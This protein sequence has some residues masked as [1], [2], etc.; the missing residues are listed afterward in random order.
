[1]DNK[2]AIAFLNS[3]TSIREATEAF[4]NTF[5][6]PEGESHSIRRKFGQLKL[7]REPF[8]KKNDLN[9]WEVIH[10]YSLQAI[11][12][13]KK[14]ISEEKIIFETELSQDTRKPI[15]QLTNKGLKKRLKP[16]LALLCSIADFENVE[17]KT[18]A[19]TCL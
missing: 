8:L 6:I 15:D 1:M 3:H 5:E 18:I 4:M 11:H 16:L 19:T 12:P 10:F 7:D 14:R 17:V 13:H 9:T 2:E